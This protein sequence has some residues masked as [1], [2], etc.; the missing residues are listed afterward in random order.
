M[1][2]T[3]PVSDAHKIVEAL[4]TAGKT[5]AVAESC[6]G[7]LLAAS[8]VDVPGASAIFK[9]G[10]VS[11]SNEIKA[12]VLGVPQTILDQHGAV[13]SEC[14]GAMAEGALTLLKT[15]IACSTTGIAGPGGA[16]PAK[17]V[18]TVWFGVARKNGPTS[19]RLFLFK[20]DRASI[21]AQ[22]VAAAQRL[23][24]EAIGRRTDET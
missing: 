7:G 12:G 16:T 1:T 13:S 19:T 3:A 21:R 15:D 6:T 23:I 2:S 22:S 14:A 24:L 9:G 10:I 11:Y 18:G 8:I 20:G 4:S 5:L 17:P